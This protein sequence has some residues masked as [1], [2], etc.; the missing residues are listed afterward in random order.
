MSGL[1]IDA[2]SMRFDLPGGETI[3]A[4]Q[5]ISLTLA[6]GELMSVLGPSGC[7]K[8]TALFPPGLIPI[9][10]TIRKGPHRLGVGQAMEPGCPPYASRPKARLPPSAGRR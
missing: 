5:D 2:V 4:L 9:S 7:G 3:Q 10:R 8:T 1:I 6:K